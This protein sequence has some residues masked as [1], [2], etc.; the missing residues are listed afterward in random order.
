MYTPW[1]IC[2]PEVNFGVIKRYARIGANNAQNFSLDAKV[3]LGIEKRPIFGQVLLVFQRKEMRRT[4]MTQRY[5]LKVN[6]K[7]ITSLLF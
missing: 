6:L 1:I 7:E 5:V 4:R 2:D 3:F